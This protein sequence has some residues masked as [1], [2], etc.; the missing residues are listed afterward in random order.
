LKQDILWAGALP[1]ASVTASIKAQ[2]Y[3]MC[4]NS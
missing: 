2:K 4:L 1:V 3:C